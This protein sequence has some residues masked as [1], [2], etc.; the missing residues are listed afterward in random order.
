MASS[1]SS[2]RAAFSPMT[3]C[4]ASA[5]EPTTGTSSRSSAELVEEK[6]L[7]ERL[8]RELRQLRNRF[9]RAARGV[10]ELARFAELF[11]RQS[12]V[13][14]ATRNA[15]TS[16]ATAIDSA[17]STAPGLRHS[18]AT[19]FTTRPRTRP[20]A[21]ALTRRLPD[22]RRATDT[23]L[24]ASRRRLDAANARARLDERRDEIGRA[25]LAG[26]RDASSDE[27]AAAID[28]RPARGA[29][30][31]PALRGTI[32]LD[33]DA[34]AARLPAQRG[35]RVERQQP[36]LEHGD[37]I[38]ELLGFAQGCASRRAARAPARRRSEMRSR[39]CRALAG[40][41]PAVGSSS[42][43]IGGSCSSA[44][45]M[46]TPL[47]QALRQRAGRVAQA[48]AEPHQRQ[49]ALHGLVRIAAARTAAR[50]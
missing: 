43:T 37:P 21:P 47:P 12:G 8:R 11:A 24:R 29:S 25:I 35:R 36:R 6:R 48:I 28:A 4:A 14:T 33:L 41:S 3:A 32:D 16:E 10:S 22:R 17:G 38:G 20:A 9:Q 39:T 34:R 13:T 44:R 50:R 2:V 15:G 49:R 5:I 19:S 23:P 1:G 40:S 18:S 45:A 42:R 27:P 7:H 46:A 31:Q 26:Q 30:V